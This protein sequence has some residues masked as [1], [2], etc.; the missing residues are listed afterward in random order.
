MMLPIVLAVR[1]AWVGHVKPGAFRI[2]VDHYPH[3]P[4]APMKSNQI[5]MIVAWCRHIEYR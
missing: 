4:I 5:G 1:N 3:R 2:I